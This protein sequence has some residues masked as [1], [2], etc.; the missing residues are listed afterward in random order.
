[1]NTEPG[2]SIISYRYPNLLGQQA[3]CAG[4]HTRGGD[5]KKVGLMGRYGCEGAVD[6]EGQGP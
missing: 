5:W 3:C 6:G 1:M 4:L 2:A